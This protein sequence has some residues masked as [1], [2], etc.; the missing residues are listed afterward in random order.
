[1]MS[2]KRLCAC[3]GHTLDRL[4]QPTVMA[5]LSKGPLHGYALVDC[6]KDSPLMKGAKPDPTGVYRLLAVLEEQGLVSHDWGESKLGPSKRMYKLTGAGSD[7]L[8]RW[9][10]ALDG[11]QRDVSRLVAEMR[12][13]VVQKPQANE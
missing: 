2:D 13:G 5:V 11:Y 3:D 8:S 7:C 12:E 6:L 10:D 1:M 4:L 9:I